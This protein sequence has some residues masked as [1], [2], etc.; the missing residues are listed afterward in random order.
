MQAAG[1]VLCAAAGP[2][3][4][5]E[6]HQPLNTPPQ[7]GLAPAAATGRPI[8]HADAGEQST[9]TAVLSPFA[10]ASHCPCLLVGVQQQLFLALFRPLLATALL[11]PRMAVRAC[12]AAVEHGIHNSLLVTLAA[13]AV[14]ALCRCCC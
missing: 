9:M 6:Q 11:W 1:C 5:G 2:L 14:L 4:P 12:S 3:L 7:L 13:N 8:R 10:T